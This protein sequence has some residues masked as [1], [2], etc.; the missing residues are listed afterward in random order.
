MITTS[1]LRHFAA[2]PS[3]LLDYLTA[4]VPYTSPIVDKDEAPDI[5][6][7]VVSAPL[8]TVI[9]TVAWMIYFV[10]YVENENDKY[11]ICSAMPEGDNPLAWVG[12]IVWRG[13]SMKAAL[14]F[15][16][17]NVI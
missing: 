2:N 15:L 12:G 17:E 4:Y 8:A 5:Y 10:G 16:A 14:E 13:S 3:F 9:L 11:F 6:D 7:Q 1:L